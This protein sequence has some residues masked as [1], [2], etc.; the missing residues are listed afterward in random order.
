MVAYAY[1]AAHPEDVTKLVL[2]EAFIPDPSLYTLPSLTPGGPGPWFF[3]FFLLT[4][5]FPE[6]LIAGNE[7]VWVD[8]FVDSMEVVKGAVTAEDVAVYAEYLRSPGHLQGTLAWFRTFPQDMVDNAAYQQTKLTMPVLAIGGE[9]GLG[10]YVA[11]NAGDY[12]SNVTGIVVPNS[13]HWIYEEHP[14]ELARMLLSFLN[15]DT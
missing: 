2:S 13:G 6:Q 8:R 12:A 11:T 3:G 10:D 5:G 4:N 1:A 15:P 7:T 14:D 9:G